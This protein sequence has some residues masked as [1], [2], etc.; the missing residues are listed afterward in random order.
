MTQPAADF[1]G[2]RGFS[3]P[4]IY[5]TDLDR[6]TPVGALS[7]EPRRHSWRTLPYSTD[8]FG[9][10]ML[11]AGPETAAPEVTLHLNATG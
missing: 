6:G 1:F 7:P 2:D 5:R 9:G 8:D 3:Q 11:L 10:V 4:P